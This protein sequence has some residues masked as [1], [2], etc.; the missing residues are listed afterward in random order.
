MYLA[1]SNITIVSKYIKTVSI[2]ATC[3]GEYILN[4]SNLYFKNA[5]SGKFL[6]HSEI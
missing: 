6:Q 4:S 5:Y 1:L 3:L 2:L